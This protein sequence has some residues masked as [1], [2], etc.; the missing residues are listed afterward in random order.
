MLGGA[1][2]WR[3]A[4]YINA[5][6]ASTALYA[7]RIAS[8]TNYFTTECKLKS[9]G[10]LVEG[11]WYAKRRT[12]NYGYYDLDDETRRLLESRGLATNMIIQEAYS[13]NSWA[14]IKM[15]HQLDQDEKLLSRTCF[16]AQPHH[17]GLP[18]MLTRVQKTKYIMVVNAITEVII[19]NCFECKLRT[20][21]T[22]TN[23]EGRLPA[24]TLEVNLRL[25]C[26]NLYRYG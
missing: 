24:Y 21:R 9:H 18:K 11:T 8:E 13:P 19:S 26:S 14:I 15:R 16:T 20:R 2:P 17:K 5:T 7:I 10:I 23:Q 4:S 22:E 6:R 25:M 1:G 12:S 3:S